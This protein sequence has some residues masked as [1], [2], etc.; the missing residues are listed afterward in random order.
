MSTLKTDGLHAVL[1]SVEQWSRRSRGN[2]SCEHSHYRCAILAGSTG[3]TAL[4]LWWIYDT[5]SW[6]LPVCVLGLRG[7]RWT[8]SNCKQWTKHSQML[9]LKKIKITE[10]KFHLT[11][12][13]RNLGLNFTVRSWFLELVRSWPG[14]LLLLGMCKHHMGLFTSQ[15]TLPGLIETVTLKTHL[16][17]PVCFPRCFLTFWYAN[18]CLLFSALLSFSYSKLSQSRTPIRFNSYLLS[19]S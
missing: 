11:Q 17:A 16:R 2:K 1:T 7:T 13:L 3:D 8:H 4:F 12:L 9:S 19:S 14:E 15:W 6:Q 10:N 18:R 5:H